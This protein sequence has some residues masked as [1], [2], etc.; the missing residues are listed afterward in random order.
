MGKWAA[1]ACLLLWGGTMTGA[2]AGAAT[3]LDSLEWLLGTWRTT[4]ANRFSEEQWTRITPE[5]W[6]GAGRTFDSATG[7]LLGVESL[8]LVLMSGEVFYL[9]KVDHNE[10]PV[11]F[12]LTR[13]GPGQAVFENPSHDFPKVLDYQLAGDDSLTVRVSDGADKGFTLA[14]VRQNP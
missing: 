13:S 11:A 7:N 9:A 8:R 1:G 3:G 4:G 5:T 2:D 12:R 14:F 10:L 6:E